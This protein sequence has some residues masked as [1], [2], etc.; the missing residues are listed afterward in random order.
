MATVSHSEITRRGFLG[1]AVAATAAL[2][3]TNSG[4]A[5]RK[6]NVIFAFSD[7]HRWQSL[8]FTEQPDLQTPHLARLASEGLTFSHCICN[9]PVC[10]PYRAIFLTGRWPYQQ[11]VIDNNI[12][13]SSEE[14]TIGKVF[15]SAGYKTSYIGKWHLTEASRAEPFGFDHSLIWTGTNTHWDQ[16]KFHPA[17]GEPV[18]PKGYNA[19]LMTDQALEFI[20]ANK[21]VPFFLALSLNPPHASFL[22]PPKEKLALYPQEGSLKY[23]ANNKET[24]KGAKK[25]EGSLGRNDWATYQGYH[26]HISAIDDEVGR[27]LKKLDDLDLTRDTIIVYTSDHGSMQGSHGLGGKRQPHDE[28]IRVPFIVRYP[29]VIPAGK[30]DDALLG[31]IDLPPTLAGLAGLPVVSTFAGRDFSP[32]LRGEAFDRPKSQLIMHIAK[33][34]ASGGKEH[35]APLFRGLRSDRFTYA[36]V[37]DGDKGG[38]L[39]DNVADPFQLNNLFADPTL[40]EQRA[41]F[42]DDLFALLKTAKDPLAEPVKA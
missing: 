17:N 1:A 41:A 23:R 7:Q 32:L 15:Q 13:L 33:N 37:L 3:A 6:P 9:Y 12:P 34:N 29:G 35:P 31:T 39:F 8:S 25:L 40:A 27:L 20:D 24:P 22:D 28:S 21:D 4:A 14:N 26:A 19:T 10:S 16:S 38:F 5:T 36:E 18:Q 30:T 42:H 2:G 11:G